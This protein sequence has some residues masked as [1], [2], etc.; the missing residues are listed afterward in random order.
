MRRTLT[1][2]LHKEVAEIKSKELNLPWPKFLRSISIGGLRGW[3]GQEI[4]FAFPVVAV[5]GENGSG[6]STVLKV[7]ACAYQQAKEKTESFTPSQF[8]LDT[9]W[10]EV[11]GVSLVYKVKEGDKERT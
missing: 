10:D 1:P 8:F 9:A 7:A 5:A 6:K 3:T 11:S 2:K 4:R